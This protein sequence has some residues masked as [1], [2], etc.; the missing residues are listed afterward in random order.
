M[1]IERTKNAARN[2]F[3]GFLFKIFNIIIPFVSRTAILYVLGAQ[4][5]GLSSLFS[6]ILSF[7]SLA[8]LGAGQAMVYSMYKPIAYNDK[9]TIKALVKLYRDYYRLIGTVI[10]LLG[11]SLMPFLRKLIHGSVPSDINIHVLYLIYLF[12]AVV[13]YWLFAYKGSILTAHQRND[14]GSKIGMIMMPISYAVMIPCLLLTK[15]YYAYVIWIP[16]FSV[17]SNII[18][19]IYVNRHY[20]DYMPEGEVEP[21]LKHEISKKVL[22]LI[23]TKLNTVVL[24]AADNLV[25][26]AFLGLNVIAMYGN[27][28]YIMSSITGF[29]GIMYSSMTAGLGN[30]LEIETLDKNYNDFQMFSFANAWMTG[31]CTICLICLYQPFMYLWVGEELMFPFPIVLL[32]GLYFYV[33][34]IRKIPTVYK[35]AAG[36]WWEDRFRPYVCMVTNVVLNIAMVQV[37]GIAGIILSTVFSLFISIPWENYTIFKYVFHRSSRGYYFKMAIYLVC[38]LLAGT[39]CFMLCSLLPQGFIALIGRAFICLIVPNVIFA[40]LNFRRKEFYGTM[41]L[42]QRIMKRKKK[43]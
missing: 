27:Y 21:E 22:A 32:F 1:K 38:M 39:A 7:L 9:K 12:N 16:I 13:T 8:D 31:W 28:Y 40:A 34:T 30:S 14:V 4:Y 33:Y 35:D 26:S 2:I 37:I 19:A 20:P 23:G 3:F 24:H 17:V 43:T 6:S 5:L 42:L 10:F 18:K 15:S 36:I 11:L 29:L 25:M 41:Q